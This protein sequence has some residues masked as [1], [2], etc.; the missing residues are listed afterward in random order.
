MN[1]TWF[2]AAVVASVFAGTVSAQAQPDAG[3][4][5]AARH[6]QLSHDYTYA[7]QYF[8]KGLL[9]DPAS[10][11]IMESTVNALIGLG[12]FDR[13][14]PVARAMVDQGKAHQIAHLVLHL[15]A[16]KAGRWDDIFYLLEN[17]RSVGP[18]VDGITQ[19]WAHLGKGDM[20]RAVASFDQVIATDGMG[21]Y[22]VTHKA[23]ALASVGDFEGAE[24]ILVAAGQ[25]GL[26][27]NRQ[28]AIAHAQILSQLGRN[29]AALTVIAAV[30]GDQRDPA[31]DAL[32]RALSSGD[33]VAYDAVRTPAHGLADLH[34][35]IA[36]LL[37]G[38][39]PDP[40]TLVYAR[41]AAHLAPGNT[42]AVL[43]SAAL[44]D[45]LEQY[46]LANDAYSM[47]GADD[48]SFHAAELGRASVLRAAGRRDAAVDVLEA[49]AVSYPDMPEVFATKGD[50]LRQAERFDDAHA[51]YTRALELYDRDHASRWFIHY[52]RAVTS[53][54]LDDWPAAETDFRAALALNPDQPQVLNYLGY[55]LVDRG[56][57]LDEALGMIR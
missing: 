37:Q 7:A 32:Y 35:T 42:A 2:S 48:P 28:S 25:N 39:A 38:E 31:V 40:V 16:A 29:D 36:G 3:A 50:T 12:Q 23:Y 20:A 5:L 56:E 45:N 9:A 8:T 18:L 33:A 51:A 21:V 49:L 1:R 6:A 43:T 13:A 41:A 15:D 4:Y 54:K 30:F 55:S 24:A 22:G 47:I 11:P 46:D 52:T 14:V 19:A 26:Q 10:M 44:L 17:G 34:L 27:Y 53:H 57:K